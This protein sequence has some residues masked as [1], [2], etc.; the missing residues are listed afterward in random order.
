[1]VYFP[2]EFGASIIKHNGSYGREQDLFEVGVLFRG[3]LCYRTPITDDVIG[4]L[5]EEEV[6][7]TCERIS[8]LS[9]SDLS[10]DDPP[11]DVEDFL[12]KLFGRIGDDL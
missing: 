9:L 6:I 7:E 12:G 11:I 8:S 3:G 1:M 5:T 10:D 4:W 2:N